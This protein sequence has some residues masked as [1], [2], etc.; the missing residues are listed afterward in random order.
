MRLF[1]TLLV[2]CIAS[3]HCVAAP[4]NI[5]LFF[6]DDLGW[7]DTSVAFHTERTVFNDRYRTPNMER[8]ADEGMRFTQAYASPICSPTRVSIMT[9]LN[10]ARHR[11]TNW[12]LRRGKS[13]DAAHP[14]LAPPEWNVNGLAPVDGIER[15]V[16]ARP[17]PARLQDAGYHT[18]HVGKA[19]LGAIGTPGADPRELGFNVNI[20]GHAAGAPGSYHAAHQFS[21]AVRRGEPAGDRVWD[22]PG[23]EDYHDG[24]I[25]LT[26][27]LT[28][29]AIKAI[30]DAARRDAPFFLHFSHYAVHTPIMPE[31]RYIDRYSELPKIEAA[32]ASMIEAMDASLGAV[33]DALERL[34][35]REKTLVIFL[36]DNGGLSAVA[37]AGTPHTHNRPLSSGK[38]SAHEGGC[39]VPMLA[40]WPSIIPAGATCRVP[41]MPED[42]FATMLAAAG[43]PAGDVDG[44]D[45]TDLLRGADRST[46][47]DLIWHVPNHWGPSG[48]GIGPASWIRRGDWKLIWYHDPERPAQFELFDLASD[49]GETRNRIADEPE[50]ARTLAAALATHLREMDAQRPVLKTTGQPVSW[51]DEALSPVTSSDE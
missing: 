50:R 30:E 40:A 37:R 15:T 51:P 14:R 34:E 7:Q 28:R 27:A 20:A 32:Y 33:L 25:D 31:A 49:L 38:G 43:A 36:S 46:E 11:V 21:G 19:H 22:V 1:V 9:G 24:P 2:L 17:L 39:R 8:L 5:V 4:P 41:V 23:L 18:V 48:P 12:T 42:I 16:H 35:L 47:R 44:I 6:V 29:E 3:D 10:A 13:T 45:S 26:E